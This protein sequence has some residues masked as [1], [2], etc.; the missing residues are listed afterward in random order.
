M[1]VDNEN[2]PLPFPNTRTQGHTMM[3]E[4]MNR[5]GYQGVFLHS[6]VLTL[7]NSVLVAVMMVVS[8][9]GFKK[10]L[11]SWRT[12]PSMT[13]GHVNKQRL[14]YSTR[15]LSNDRSMQKHLKTSAIRQHEVTL[16]GDLYAILLPSMPYYWFSRT[17]VWQHFEKEC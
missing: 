3:R 15:H 2:F 4:K 7:W 9:N 12:G 14:T 6:R 16:K 13:I 10:V 11:D 1:Q 5:D 8:T 17:T